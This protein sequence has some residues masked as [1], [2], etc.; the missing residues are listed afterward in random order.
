M[1]KHL[2]KQE[3]LARAGIPKRE[4]PKVVSKRRMEEEN[5]RRRGDLKERE[6]GEEY[7]RR[8]EIPREIQKRCQREMKEIPR[9]RDAERRKEPS[10][11]MLLRTS[12]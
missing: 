7:R 2:K 11:K 10:E 5:G 3:N 1:E 12:S 8:R 9:V 4:T 6:P